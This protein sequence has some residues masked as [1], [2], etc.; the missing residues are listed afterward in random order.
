MSRNICV[1]LDDTSPAVQDEIRSNITA[2]AEKCGF[3][4]YFYTREADAAADLP[5]FEVM[6]GHST[7][8]AMN[9]PNLK[10]MCCS[11][12]GVAPFCQ[13]GVL[14]EDCILTNSAGAYGDTIAEHS[15]MVLLMLLRRMP[16]YEEIVSRREWRNRLP[17]RSILGSRITVLGAG[18]IGITGYGQGHALENRSNEPVEMIALIIME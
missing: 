9:A 3:V 15:I 14:S 6:Y 11:W 7:D 13:D 8:L 10:W 5:K 18:D 2:A 1:W 16:E 4:P 17:I 12:A